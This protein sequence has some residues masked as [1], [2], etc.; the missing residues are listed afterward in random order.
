MRDVLAIIAAVNLTALGLAMWHFR[1]T[2]HEPER[3]T[4]RPNHWCATRKE[5]RP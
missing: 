3:R 2:R 4:P 5:P 1:R